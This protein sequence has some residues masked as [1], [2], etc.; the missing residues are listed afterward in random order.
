M[1]SEAGFSKTQR[2][3]D[4]H[5]RQESNRWSN[6]SSSSRSSSDVSPREL[7]QKRHPGLHPTQNSSGGVPKQHATPSVASEIQ[8]QAR[9]SPQHMPWS[10]LR[11]PE[12]RDSSGQL[13]LLK[14]QPRRNTA[15]LT[16]PKKAGSMA[17]STH[18]L[19]G[20]SD[21]P[22]RGGDLG[23]SWTSAEPASQEVGSKSFIEPVTSQRRGDP[24][25]AAL[26]RGSERSGSDSNLQL[27][28]PPSLSEPGNEPA[29]SSK[30]SSRHSKRVDRREAQDLSARGDGSSSSK[31]RH[32]NNRK[33]QRAS[34]QKLMLS[35]ALQKANYAVVLD[36][37]QDVVSA[38]EA[39]GEACDLLLRVMDRSTSEEEKRKLDTI[40][41]F[42]G[43]KSLRARLMWSTVYNLPKSNSRTPP[44]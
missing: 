32:H 11:S 6:S 38:T 40:V 14:S 1:F 30:H 41:R 5:C 2:A 25:T 37:A 26:Q 10:S 8:H 31:R 20:S 33:K 44:E 3:T 24:R 29:D 16:S 21:S 42:W 15:I 34:S 13:K 36:N 28:A 39:Y 7:P 19:L 4:P 27:S 23:N 9:L 18:D 35:E 17:S 12:L 22:R 43:R